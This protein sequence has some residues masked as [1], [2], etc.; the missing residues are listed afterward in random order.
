MAVTVG[1]RKYEERSRRRDTLYL[2]AE[3]L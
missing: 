2:L 3:P 1:S